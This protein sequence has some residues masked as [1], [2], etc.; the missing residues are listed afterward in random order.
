MPNIVISQVNLIN[1]K[2]DIKKMRHPSED[3]PVTDQ[4]FRY[5]NEMDWSGQQKAKWI[6][7][8]V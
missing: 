5:F 1:Y 6:S 4:L 7:I 3:E 8:I 2:L